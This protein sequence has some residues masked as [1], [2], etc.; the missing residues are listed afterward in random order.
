MSYALEESEMIG[1][2]SN[3]NNSAFMLGGQLISKSAMMASFMILSRYMSDMTFG[4]L[5]LATALGQI[6]FFASDMGAS[7]IVNRRLSQE[8][9]SPSVLLRPASTLR[10]LLSLTC[11]LILGAGST[12][13]ITNRL[14][15]SM[16]VII[17][18]GSCFESFLELCYSVFR[19]SEKML[20]E[21]L[22]RAFTGLTQLVLILAVVKFDLGPI[23]IASAY[24][25]SSFAAMI[26]SHF[27]VKRLGGSIV[28][29]LNFRIMKSLL[30]DGW[31][32][33]LMCL[34]MVAWQRIDTVILSRTLGTEVVG[35][36]QECYR[37]LDTLILLIAPTLLPG[38][39]FPGMCRAFSES[40]ESF[41][42]YLRETTGLVAGLASISSI[43]VFAGGLELLEFL[44]GPGYLRGLSES[45]MRNCIY[46]IAASVPVVFWMNFLLGSLLATGR[47]KRIPA[48]AATGLSI[49]LAF[50]IVFIPKLGILAPAIAVIL[51]SIVLA[52]LLYRALCDGKPLRIGGLIWKGLLPVLPAIAVLALLWNAPLIPRVIAST[53]T[54][55]A[56]WAGLGGLK[57]L[58]KCRTTSSGLL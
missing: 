26:A 28:P 42:S 56:I 3:I 15:V 4:I 19:S 33:G 35:A 38:A 7:L 46:T 17:G 30:A 6:V 2:G 27:M 37:I 43:F 34:L 40:R 54:F 36:W 52:L 32:L 22:T 12:L 55:A 13:I 31:P 47:Q 16:I 39:L 50:N 11:L 14:A 58:W 44:W 45:Q 21:G 57:P 8:Q 29:A 51:S 48:I 24:A 1:R 5:V 53:G 41:E 25:A 20:G 10:L 23:A 9:T 18:M 49:S